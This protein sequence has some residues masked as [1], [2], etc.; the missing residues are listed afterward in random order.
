M[1]VEARNIPLMHMFMP[2]FWK[3]IKEF[4]IIEDNDDY[5]SNL[6]KKYEDLYEIYPDGLARELMGTFVKYQ[7]Q[8]YKK[9]YGKRG[10]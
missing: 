7:E 9:K 10:I 6:C 3:F 8:M 1:K 2:E 4:Y 5:W